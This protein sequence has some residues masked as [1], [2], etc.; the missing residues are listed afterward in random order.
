M[1]EYLFSYGTLQPDLAPAGVESLVRQFRHIGGGFIRGILYDLGDYPGAVICETALKVWGQA[2][3]LP[4]NPDVLS[5]LD[6][7]E[8][9]NPADLQHSEFVRTGC[10]AT[11][12]TGMEIKLWV[13]VYNRDPGP[14]PRILD[15]D[16]ARYRR[17]C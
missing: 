4:E 17:H 15:G 13:Y 2:F 1:A 3:E 16:F 14:A 10:V 11:L 5:R 8:G 7:Y 12:E 6:E 9:F